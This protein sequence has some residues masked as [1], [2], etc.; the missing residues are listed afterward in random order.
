MADIYK[1]ALLI[2][3]ED[4]TKFLVVQKGHTTDQWLEGLLPNSVFYCNSQ[5]FTAN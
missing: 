1:S 2:L 5:I 4:H 3:S